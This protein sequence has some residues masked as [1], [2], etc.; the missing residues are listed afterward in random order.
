MVDFLLLIIRLIGI[1]NILRVQ[2][3]LTNQ[4]MNASAY[5]YFALCDYQNAIQQFE[6]AKVHPQFMHNAAYLQE[7]WDRANR[8]RIASKVVPESVMPPRPIPTCNDLSYLAYVE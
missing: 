7:I 8:Y 4:T 1:H 6:N 2:H 3:P 5:E